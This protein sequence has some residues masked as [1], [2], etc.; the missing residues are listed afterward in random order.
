MQGHPLPGPGAPEQA[1][2][3]RTPHPSGPCLEPPLWV[4]PVS[5]PGTHKWLSPVWEEDLGPAGVRGVMRG[6]LG[7]GRPVGEGLCTA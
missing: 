2:G 1:Q 3:R 4:R 5:G 7:W 6:A